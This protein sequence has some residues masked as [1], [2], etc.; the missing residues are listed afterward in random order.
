MIFHRSLRTCLTPPTAELE[1]Q[2]PGMVTQDCVV[3]PF[4]LCI[5]R[6]V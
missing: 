2:P 3:S 5:G 6:G 1:L 4:C